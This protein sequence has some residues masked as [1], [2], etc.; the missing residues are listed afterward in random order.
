M[1]THDNQIK[2]TVSNRTVIRVLLIILGSYIFL[3]FVIRIDHILELFFISFFLAIALNPAVSWIAKS[4]KLKSRIAATGIAYLVVVAILVAFFALVLPPLVRQTINYAE[5]LPANVTSL[6]NPNT[7]SGRFIKKHKLESDIANLSQDIRNRTH[8]LSS[9]SG[10]TISTA[11]KIGNFITSTIVVF[12][13]I[14]MMLVEGPSLLK[15]YWNLRFGKYEWHQE[16]AQKMYKI[17]SGYVNGQVVLA[18]IGGAFALVALVIVTAILNV[19]VNDVALAGIIVFTG[20]IPMIGHIIGDVIVILACL[21]VSWPLALIMAIILI[22]Y[23]QIE[24]VTLQPYVQAKFNEL[25]PLLVF[26]AALVGFAGAGL[27]GAFVAI[28]LAGCL[29]I[30]LKEYLVHRKIV[31]VS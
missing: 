30:L 19:S 28:P 6:Q 5:N 2:V 3:K 17:I 22:A 7:A 16:L 24:N 21:F 14:F 9:L 18:L 10:A 31:Q 13:L 1:A 26:M 15:R 27:L 4:L 11:T 20:L 12:V 8:N 23:L 25:T 29:K